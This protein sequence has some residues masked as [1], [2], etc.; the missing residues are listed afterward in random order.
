MWSVRASICK[1]NTN[2][3]LY[4]LTIMLKI[5]WLREYSVRIALWNVVFQDVGLNFVVGSSYKACWCRFVSTILF[6]LKTI[7]YKQVTEFYFRPGMN[8]GPT[9]TVVT[10]VRK[11]LPYLGVHPLFGKDSGFCEKGHCL[12]IILEK[13]LVLIHGKL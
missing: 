13:E 6:F 9:M 1:Q 11:D 7:I 8:I 5:T 2:I 10:H 3:S 4:P 12:K